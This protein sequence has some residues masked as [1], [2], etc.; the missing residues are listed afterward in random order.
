MDHSEQWLSNASGSHALVSPGAGSNRVIPNTRLAA[1]VGRVMNQTQISA[2]AKNAVNCI[3]SVCANFMDSHSD[4]DD[5]ADQQSA[6]CH[7]ADAGIGKLSSHRIV[8]QNIA[9]TG[10]G[11]AYQ[12][13][14][15]DR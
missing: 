7:H 14:H 13:E 4:P 12:T 1:E 3:L 15:Y 8:Y 2:A 6:N 5:F 9:V 10:I 11:N